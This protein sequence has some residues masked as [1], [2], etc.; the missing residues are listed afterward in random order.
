[1]EVGAESSLLVKTLSLET[2]YSFASL[3]HQ[4]SRHSHLR[5]SDCDTQHSRVHLMV[6]HRDHPLSTVTHSEP[7]CFK[8]VQQQPMAETGNEVNKLKKWR[9]RLAI[10]SAL[11]ARLS[12]MCAQTHTHSSSASAD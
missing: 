11:E 6:W 7:E 4:K 2:P 12:F 8:N 5:M 9:N 3:A 1:M 10:N